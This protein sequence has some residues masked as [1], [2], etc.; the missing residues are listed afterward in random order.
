MVKNECDFVD[1]LQSLTSMLGRIDRFMTTIIDQ[2]TIIPLSRFKLYSI[3][4]LGVSGTCVGGS[5]LVSGDAMAV[6]A[7]CRYS[8]CQVT[9]TS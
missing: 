5:R 4:A 3:L 8:K 6:H 7:P 2:L 1:F 9:V